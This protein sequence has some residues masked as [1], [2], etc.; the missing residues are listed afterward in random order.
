MK[1]YKFEIFTQAIEKNIKSGVYKPGQKLPSVREFKDYYGLSMSTVQSGYEYLMIIGLVES[2]PKSGYYVSAKNEMLAE[3]EGR[4]R[5][6]VVRD[7]VFEQGLGLT[8][9]SPV[10][11]GFSEFNVAAPG[12]LLVPQKL[13]LRTMQQV[14][15]EQ[16]AG[17]LRYYPSNGSVQLKDNIIRRAASYQTLLHADEL[18]ITDGALQALYI[19][20]AAA[21]EAG[22][23]VAV[24]SP[25]VFSV[26][27]VIRVL[28]LRVI[29]IPVLTK[30][31]FDI[32]FFRQ[33]CQGSAVKAVVLTPNF[34]NP[35]GILLSDEQKIALLAIAHKYN[36]VVI[37]NDIY[38]T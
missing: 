26:L 12:D 31:G 24:E 23:I 22:D 25:C 3:P 38:E 13:L 11:R 19:A 33:A 28:K 15:R 36:V 16:G 34:H 4:R 7:A 9:A 21:C 8:T 6:P 29:E 2:V 17:L 37:E 14:I 20:L 35:T 5:P 1:S 32:D 18:L 27:E 10:G 30:D